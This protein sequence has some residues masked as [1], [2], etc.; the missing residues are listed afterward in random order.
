MNTILKQTSEDPGKIRTQLK[1]IKGLGDVGV[2]VF[3]DTAQHLWTCLAPFIDPRS[4]KTAK[5]IGL[6]DDVQSLWEEIGKN[7]DTMAKLSGAL[8]NVRLE[9]REK[10]FAS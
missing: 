7:P 9:G 1:T 5:N 3:M 10:D 2:D 6:G 4:M 8:T